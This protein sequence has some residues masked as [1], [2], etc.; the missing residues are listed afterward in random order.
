MR[1]RS[2]GG[3]F[4]CRQPKRCEQLLVGGRSSCARNWSPSGAAGHSGQYR[5]G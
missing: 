5:Y 2:S 4:T 3:R 1:L